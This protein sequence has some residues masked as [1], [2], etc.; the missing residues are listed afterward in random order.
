MEQYLIGNYT[1]NDLRTAQKI[2]LSFYIDD[3]ELEYLNLIN[4]NAKIEISNL[5]IGE[6]NID[7]LFRLLNALK[8]NN[9]KNTI[10]FEID[11]RRLLYKYSEQ[12]KN[13]SN[14]NI[15]FSCELMKYTINEYIEENEKIE[16]LGKDIKESSKKDKVYIK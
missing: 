16:S 12:L 10:S 1:E 9:K 15:L 3:N 6:D 8:N 2:E 11:N 4:D 7:D 13:Y 5:A 14:L